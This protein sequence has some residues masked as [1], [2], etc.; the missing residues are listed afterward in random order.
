MKLKQNN[1][2]CLMELLHA[3]RLARQIR[4]FLQARSH[5]DFHIRYTA[6]QGELPTRNWK[7][8]VS[9]QNTQYLL[10]TMPAVTETL[11]TTTLFRYIRGRMNGAFRMDKQVLCHQSPVSMLIRSI[12]AG[13][14]L[15]GSRQFSESQI[16]A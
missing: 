9:Y 2:E 15:P 3:S 12:H 13:P 1:E 6:E 7:Q 8:K 5:V 4:A 14:K 10:R 16:G 11:A